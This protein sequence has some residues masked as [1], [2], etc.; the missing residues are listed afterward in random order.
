MS[1]NGSFS[2]GGRQR[3]VSTMARS[4][5]LAFFVYIVLEGALRKWVWP[6]FSNELFALKDI[7]LGFAFV[8]WLGSRDS[9]RVA[10]Q[11]GE[12]ALWG[13]WLLLTVGYAASGGFSVQS[14]IGLRYYLAPLPLLYLVPAVLRDM[15]DL[16]RLAARYLWITLAIAALGTY[17]YLSPVDSAINQYAWRSELGGAVAGFGLREDSL[18]GISGDR[19]RITGS[20]SYI[21]PYAAFLQALWF[22]AW[23]MLL[24]STRRRERLFAAVALVAILVNIAMTG[25][26]AP[27]LLSLIVAVPFA[28][29]VFRT[30]TGFWY[31]L[32]VLAC[33]LAIPYLSM[34]L[35]VEPFQFILERDQSAG[36]APERILGSFLTPLAT[37]ND[38][39]AL[40]EGIGSSFWGFAELGRVT[41]TESS[42][43]EVFHDRIGIELG[44]FGYALTLLIKVIMV[45]KTFLLSM[46]ARTKTIR[47]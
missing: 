17:Q 14:L 12:I 34:T 26:R 30:F 22:I 21:S 33:F 28:V 7:I 38:M 15:R 43:A 42:F 5:T 31:Q 9:V 6:E 2:A 4:A 36:D 45:A 25:S 44:V 41:G 8:A 32:G 13:A 3:S 10:L 47:Y 27:L 37:F 18:L 35:L 29:T 39:Q 24:Q 1:V 19:P 40:G 23:V 46:D 11:P 20:F 16:D